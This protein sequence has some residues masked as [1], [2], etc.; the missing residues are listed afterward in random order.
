MQRRKSALQME[1]LLAPLPAKS[2]WSR[3][4]TID[5]QGLHSRNESLKF[6][7]MNELRIK[8]IS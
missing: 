7:S 3:S 2:R 8:K 1:F 4:D 6:D 5:P